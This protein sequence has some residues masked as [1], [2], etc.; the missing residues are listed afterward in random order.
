MKKPITIITQFC[1]CINRSHLQS[2]CPKCRNNSK[3]KFNLMV[4]PA[5][6]TK[7]LNKQYNN[8]KK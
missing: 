5:I 3:I 1:N 7:N 2:P 4:P 6:I 8:H